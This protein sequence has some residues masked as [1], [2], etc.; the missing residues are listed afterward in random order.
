MKRTVFLSLALATAISFGCNE[1]ARNDNGDG[2]G[3]RST[4]TSGVDR[5]NTLSNADKSFLEEAA[6]ANIAE[7]ELGRMAADRSTNPSVKRFAQMMVDDHT[8]A[9]DKLKRIASNHNVPLP[10][11]L[12]D[13][14]RELH[15]KL[16][17]LK[18]AEFDREYINAMVDG[19]EDVLDTLGSRVDRANPQAVVA[20]QSDNLVTMDINRWAAESYPVVQRHLES[21]KELNE[22]LQK[23]SR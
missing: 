13:K 15:D 4:G 18:G 10:T 17:T 11:A 7:V 1:A 20:E 19:H 16:A 22:T 14:H 12:D 9:G 3:D 6:V 21:A 2:I 8:M 23:A 5:T